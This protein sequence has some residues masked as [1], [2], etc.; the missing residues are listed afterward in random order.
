MKKVCCQLSPFSHAQVRRD[1]YKNQ[2]QTCLKNGNQVLIQKT[3]ESGFSLNDKKGQILAEV[4]HEVQKHE[5]QA[6]ADKR[7]IQ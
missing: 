5:L 3:S 4:G 6:E 7:S 1:P 2:V